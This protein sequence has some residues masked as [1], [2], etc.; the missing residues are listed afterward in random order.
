MPNPLQEALGDVPKAPAAPDPADFPGVPHAPSLGKR[1][2]ALSLVG[3]MRRP[4]AP[5]GPRIG[6]SHHDV[7]AGSRSKT[8]VKPPKKSIVEQA[9]L[10]KA[11][12]GGRKEKKKKIAEPTEMQEEYAPEEPD[13]SKFAGKPVHRAVRNASAIADKINPLRRQQ[14]EDDAQDTMDAPSSEPRPASVQ[15]HHDETRRQI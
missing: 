7:R 13:V 6:E 15:A 14:R 4:H 5:A 11:V 8:I 10:A 12:F 1:G 2:R 3:G 9:A